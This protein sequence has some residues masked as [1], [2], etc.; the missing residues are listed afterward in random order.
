MTKAADALAAAGHDVRVVSTRQTEWAVQADEELRR[1]RSWQWRVVDYRSSASRGTYLKVGLRSRVAH[2]MAERLGPER[3]PF[4]V[5]VHAYARAH[6]ELVS[7]AI[8]T[9]RRPLLRGDDGRP[10]GNG[11]SGVTHGDALWTE[12]EDF[13]SEEQVGA[14]GPLMNALADRI[15]RRVLPRAS[16]VTASSGPMS[17][18]F[19]RRYHVNT[20]TVHNTFPLPA[21]APDIAH[22]AG[23][24]LR[25]YWFSQTI[26]EGR[27]LEGFVTAAGRADVP[28]ELHLR[29]READ[30]YVAT[31]TALVSTVAPKLQI[32]THPPE[33]PEAMVSLCRG[34]DVG[35]AIE[36][37]R[38]LSR[39]LSLTNKA[40]TYILGGLAVVLT[41]TDGQRSLA[42]DLD[43]GAL[44]Y[45]EGDL[46]ALAQGLRRWYQEPNRL[47][48]ARR[49]AW[50][51]ASRSWHWEHPSQ[52]G[53]LVATVEQALS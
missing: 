14:D 49:A 10:R 26:G 30:G 15:M 44:M 25:V 23:A 40:L 35:L 34:Y 11:R 21:Q 3:V 19:L 16:F 38:T 39:R 17:A 45:R 12:F 42:A 43:E 32:M 13:H 6:S 50:S 9:A 4:R 53:V 47:L 33:S 24:P 48:A 20:A 36:E 37:S 8:G 51:A 46:D 18:E 41:D 2:L 29:G 22:V 5:G 52:R 27:G 1:T 7:A 31:L 28:V